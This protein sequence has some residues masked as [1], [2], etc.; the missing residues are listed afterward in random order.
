M[1]KRFAGTMAAFAASCLLWMSAQAAP[2]YR[3]VLV[4]QTYANGYRSA[5]RLVYMKRGQI[6]HIRHEQREWRHEQRQLRHYRKREH[7]LERQAR[8]AQ[9]QAWRLRNG[10]R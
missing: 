2:H 9:M 10:Y 6:R 3:P 7:R 4:Q 8:H 5:P 1:M